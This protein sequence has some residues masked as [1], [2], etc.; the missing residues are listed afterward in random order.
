MAGGTLGVWQNTYNDTITGDALWQ[1]PEFKGFYADVRWVRF[2]TREGPITI[3][4]NQDDLALQVLTPK[5]PSPRLAGHTAPAFPAAGLS[6]LHAIPP[7][8]SKF[9]TAASSGPSGQQAVAAGEY[10]GS[11]SFYFGP[12]P[13]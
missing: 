9:A 12:L 10:Q 6:F 1:Y 5:F 11:V 7:I 13:R 2:Q 4:V 3:L 8:G